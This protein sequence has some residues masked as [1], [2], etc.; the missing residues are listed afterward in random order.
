MLILGACIVN[1]LVSDVA[2]LALHVVRY[3]FLIDVVTGFYY[4]AT[5]SISSETGKLTN[6]LEWYSG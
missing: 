1:S 5:Y 6:I 3:Y 4:T 2:L